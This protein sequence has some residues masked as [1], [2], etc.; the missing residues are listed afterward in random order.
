MQLWRVRLCLRVE[1]GGADEGSGIA[2]VFPDTSPRGAG[3]EGEDKDWDF[4]TGEP[5]LVLERGGELMRCRRGVLP[6][7]DGAGLQEALQHVRA[8]ATI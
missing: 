4:G 1:W 2:L 6:Q 3:I 5:V 7:C 8:F